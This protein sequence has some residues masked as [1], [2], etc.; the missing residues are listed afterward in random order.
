MGLVKT[1]TG[2]VMDSAEETRC[3]LRAARTN[4]ILSILGARVLL[5]VGLAIYLARGIVRPLSDAMSVAAAIRDGKLDNSIDDGGQ[6]ETG[7]LLDSLDVD[8]EL[9]CVAR[10][11]EGRGFARPDRRDRPCAGSHRIRHERHRARRER[12]FRAR[13]GLHARRGH[14]QAPQPVR[15]E[16]RSRA[17]P[18]TARSGKSSTVASRTS[19]VTSASPRAVAKSGSRRLTTRSRT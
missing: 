13:H 6:D 17:A 9:R 11:R 15:R 4:L 2:D 10:D 19:T 3:A 7:K 14:R 1:H 16:P 18:N 12:E 8:A 5:G